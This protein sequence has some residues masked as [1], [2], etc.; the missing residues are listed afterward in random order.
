MRLGEKVAKIEELAP[1]PQ[2]GV[3]VQATLESGKLLRAQ[4]LLYAVGRQGTT[5]SLH[6][7]KV[8][9]KADDRERLKV[10]Q[11]YQTEAPHIYG[12]GMSSVFLRWPA[13]RWS[14]AALPSVTPS[15]CRRTR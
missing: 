5:S 8:G 10:N 6:L 12:V 14:R 1:D 7:E 2:N 9:L 4:T 11:F 3:L 13:P 15:A